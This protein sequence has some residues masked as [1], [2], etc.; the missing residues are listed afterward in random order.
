[1]RIKHT[2]PT[3][4]AVATVAEIEAVRR[5]GGELYREFLH[6]PSMSAGLYVLGAGAQDPQA[7]HM[8][9][10]VYYVIDGYGV[11]DIAGTDQPVGPGSLV[12]VPAHAA[13]RF[14]S[15]DEELRVLV[16][17]APAEGSTA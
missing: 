1:M 17:F 11:I 5:Q 9:D 2:D 6:V 13:H 14:H 8:E 16:F 10:E 12:F 15:I 3:M 4:G 7:P